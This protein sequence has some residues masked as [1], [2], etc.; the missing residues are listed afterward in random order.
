MSRAELDELMRSVG[1]GLALEWPRLNGDLAQRV[2]AAAALL[3]EL[4]ALTESS[5]RTADSSCVVMDEEAGDQ[6][7]TGLAAISS[8]D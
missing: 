1:T 7:V 8:R 2:T 4:G 3:Q 6:A 5:H